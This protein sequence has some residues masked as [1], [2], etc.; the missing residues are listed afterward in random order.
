M[1]LLE[2]LNNGDVL[3]SDGATGTNLQARGLPVGI[4]SERWVLENPDGIMQLQRDFVDA[5]SDI[6]LTCT[7][8]A[9]SI[10]L[11]AEGL[12]DRADELNQKA[13]ALAREVIGKNGLVGGSIGPTG[14]MMKPMG[15]LEVEQAETVFSQQAKSLV[16]GG[17]DFLVIETQFDI[18][19]AKAAIQGARQVTDLPI[20]CSFSY[21]RGTKTMM[22]VSAKKMAKAIIPLGVDVLGVNCGKSLDENLE[23]LKELQENS[24]LP[25]WF[26]PNAGLPKLDEA[27][28]TYFDILPEEMGNRIKEGLQFGAR[29][30]G[31]CCG[32]SPQHLQQIATQVKKAA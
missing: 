11:E 15:L 21:D 14:Q 3:I 24:D 30:F 2:R 1:G 31:G 16:S 5:G 6:I 23:V 8:G 10:K 20:V 18:E 29:I 25:L 26:K 9:T 27:G 12:A 32:T 17:V 28:N 19:E 13:V 22:G 7:F 4:S